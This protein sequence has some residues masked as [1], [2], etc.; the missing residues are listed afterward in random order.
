MQPVRLVKVRGQMC[1]H[2]ASAQCVGARCTS[3]CERARLRRLGQ[4]GADAR[5]RARCG[6][7][8]ATETA[9]QGLGVSHGIGAWAQDSKAYHAA[10]YHASHHLDEVPADGGQLEIEIEAVRSVA[11]SNCAFELELD[12]VVATDGGVLFACWTIGRRTTA[13]AGSAGDGTSEPVALRNELR[14]ALPR[15]PIKQIAA[16]PVMLHTTLARVFE[17]PGGGAEALAVAAEKLTASLCGL[18]ARIGELHVV[19][20]HDKL[21]L[22]TGGRVTRTVLPMRDDC[23]SIAA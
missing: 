8:A 1:A 10:L 15:S 7:R 6:I 3:E 18:R 9:L 21:A 5:A 12:R 4:G 17:V 20:E 19:Y 13:P 11:A 22:A 16:Q 2:W 14:A 23:T